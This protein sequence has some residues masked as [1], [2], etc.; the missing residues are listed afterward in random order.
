MKSVC[1]HVCDTCPCVCESLMLK[2][3]CAKIK[4]VIT[5]PVRSIL[6]HVCVPQ[7]NHCSEEEKE[8]PQSRNFDVLMDTFS[9]HEFMIRKVCVCLLVSCVVRQEA[10]FDLRTMHVWVHSASFHSLLSDKE[11]QPFDQPQVQVVIA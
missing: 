9:L 10:L 3:N 5:L 7:F 6:M 11:E 1:L 4:N 8:I 2:S